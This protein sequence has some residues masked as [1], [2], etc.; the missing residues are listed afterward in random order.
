MKDYKYPP[1]EEALQYSNLTALEDGCHSVFAVDFGDIRL[2]YKLVLN[3]TNDLLTKNMRGKIKHALKTIESPIRNYYTSKIDFIGYRESILHTFDIESQVLDEWNKRG[4]PS[5]QIL[6]K[7]EKALVY[8]YLNALNFE[9]VLR[10]ENHIS[11]EYVQLLDL[12]TTIRETAKSENNPL[13][14]HP[15][16]L[17]KNFLYLLD[18]KETIAIDPGLKLKHLPLEELDARINLM[19]LYNLNKFNSGKGY[20]NSFL[21][22]LTKEEIKHIREFKHPLRKDVSAYFSARQ[23][24]VSI[25]RGKSNSDYLF[26]YDPNNIKNINHLLDK[27]V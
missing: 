26:W 19:F 24:F 11:P 18:N 10:K 25:L 9:K 7:Q 20:M 8:K 13:L 21:E 15:D 6:E 27:H 23:K 2:V 12:I 17:P 14:L 16:M 4:I 22:R 1:A 5:M 3:Q